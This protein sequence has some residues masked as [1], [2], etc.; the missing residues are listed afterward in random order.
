MNRRKSKRR[1]FG[2]SDAVI[3]VGFLCV[4][5]V[6]KKTVRLDAALY[7]SAPFNDSMIK[8][9]LIFILSVHNGKSLT[10]KV[11]RRREYV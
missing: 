1:S 3:D 4:V 5:W 2:F 6:N 8:N 7:A 10:E 11:Y 9:E